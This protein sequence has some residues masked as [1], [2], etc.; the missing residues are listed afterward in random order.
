MVKNIEFSSVD[1]FKLFAAI[2]V[3]CIHSHP[4]FNNEDADYYLTCFCR[5]AVPFFFCFSSF[6]FYYK[7][8]H[9]ISFYVKR[10]LILYVAW[11]ILEL[12]LVYYRIFY[13]QPLSIASIKFIR[14]LLIHNTF[15]ASWFITASWQA[16]LIV[17]LLCYKKYFK[18]LYVLGVICFMFGIFNAMYS[19]VLDNIKYGN[20][21]QM[22]LRLICASNSFI[23]AIPYCIMG[24]YL[25]LNKVTIKNY[26][27]ICVLIILGVFMIMEVTWCKN[28][29]MITDSYFSLLPVTFF[30]TLFLISNNINVPNSITKL[31]RQLSILI[32]F[33]HYIIIVML[34]NVFAME[35]SILM[36][37]I[38]LSL[39]FIL[40]FIMIKLSEK[41]SMLKYFM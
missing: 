18:T 6:I 5:I 36:F 15:Y 35:Y 7:N 8:N 38:T 10:M 14:G 21:I 34:Q 27:L 37:L 25:A 11:F 39:S 41:Y 4:L 1:L 13:N 29:Y 30:I 12:P 31:C 2:L 23:V 40:S 9:S 24:R 17:Y 3:V 28:M 20:Y 32:F 33:I 22:F 26:I 16:M 19:G